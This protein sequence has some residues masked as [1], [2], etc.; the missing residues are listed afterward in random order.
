M[1]N[2]DKQYEIA[3]W[4]INPEEKGSRRIVRIPTT[5]EAFDDYYR[6]INA[7]RKAEQR[8]GRC[9]CPANCRLL[10]NMDCDTCRY[11]V[12]GNMDSLNETIEDDD[13]NT[14]ERID[15]IPDIGTDIEADYE[16]AD[17]IRRLREKL[18]D[19]TPEYQEICR[20]IMDGMNEREMAAEMNTSKTTLHR[21]KEDAL[22]ILREDLD[23]YFI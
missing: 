11:R 18:N 14:T 7:F 2:Q 16:Y 4:E 17:L 9:V 1:T 12:S 23:K 15:T 20:L 3:F 5:K 13:G 10:C 21:H 19:L 22:S 6:P 8:H